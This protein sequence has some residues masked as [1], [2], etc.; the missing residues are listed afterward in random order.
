[1]SA[2]GALSLLLTGCF[3]ASDNERMLE[4]PASPLA[5]QAVSLRGDTLRLPTLD[6]MT[7][8]S[9][10]REFESALAAYQQAPDEAESLIWL[11]R[12]LAYLGRYREAIDVYS[13]G[14]DRFPEDAR[15]YRHRG[16]RHLTTRRLADALGDFLVATQ[17]LLNQDDE[18]EPDGLPNA[19]GIPTST[20]K[21]NVWY[22]LGLTHYLRGDYPRAASAY[23]ECLRFSTN[24]DMDVAATHWLYMTLRRTGHANEAA[25]ALERIA[26]DA[27]IIENHTYFDLILM[28]KGLRTPAELLD[29]ARIGDAL[30]NATLAYGIASWHLAQGEG[31]TARA[32]YR[33]IVDGPEWAA[34][35]YLAA[36]ADLARLATDEQ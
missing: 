16:H 15:L 1:M 36:E 22:H 19:R 5:V 27:D 13:W 18:I 12:R 3:G 32:M 8:A 25:T 14:I 10:Q 9:R 4:V 2:T 34:F 7:G 6:S 17:L 31:E 30:S 29:A 35:G 21:T 23:R 11:G 26:V 28:Y 33:D 20:L 24:P